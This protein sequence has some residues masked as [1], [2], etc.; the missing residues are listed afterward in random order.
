MKALMIN[1]SPDKEG[2]TYTALK[3]I[4]DTLAVEGVD[5]EIV[6]LGK[7]A[8]NDCI[9]CNACGKLRKNRCVFD[10]DIVNRLL[11]KAEEC[12]ALVIGGPVYYANTNARTLAVLNRMFY[13]G[14]RL[15]A[16]KPGAVVTV[17]RRAGT[18]SSL[19]DMTKYLTISNMFVVGSQYWNM[20]HGFTPDD[21]R[22]DLEGMQTMRVLARNMAYLMKCLENGKDIPKPE[23]EKRAWTHF[24]M[25]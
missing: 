19:D 10:N 20:V 22:K 11:E 3:E 4:A 14:D 12:D 21:V 24:I 25:D 18:T 9:G 7:D 6:W 17:A 5:S 15:F 13:A 16:L 8:V 1:G 23:K 2:C